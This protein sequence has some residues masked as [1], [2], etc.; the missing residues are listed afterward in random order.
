[1][2]LLNF[3]KTQ[4]IGPYDFMIAAHARSRG[5]TLIST[6][7]KEFDRVAGLRVENWV[8]TEAK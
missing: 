7:T 3:S 4:N 8:T 5:L 6:N 1:M 2:F